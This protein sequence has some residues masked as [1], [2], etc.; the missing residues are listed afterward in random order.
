MSKTVI[1][2]GKLLKYNFLPLTT[3]AVKILFTSCTTTPTDICARA[4]IVALGLFLRT[5]TRAKLHFVTHVHR[6]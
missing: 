6:D 5:V 3:T 4:L 2:G 1:P